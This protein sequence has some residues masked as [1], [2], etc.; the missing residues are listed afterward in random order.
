MSK[1]NNQSNSLDNINFVRDI[2]SEIAANYG[3]G[4]SLRGARRVRGG[5][6]VG[7]V[8]PDVTLYDNRNRTGRSFR[9]NAATNDGVLNFGSFND[10]ASSVVIKRGVWEFY[11]DSDYNRGPNAGGSGIFSEDP[12]SFARGPGTYVLGVNNDALSS[13]KRIG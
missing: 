8:D 3:G 13:L 6:L 2:S 4:I 10:E 11:S 7:G 1:I 5:G 9:V 12:R